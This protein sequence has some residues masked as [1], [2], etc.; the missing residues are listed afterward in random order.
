MQKKRENDPKKR[1]LGKCWIREGKEKK[2]VK[3]LS[4]ND[5]DI[6]GNDDPESWPLQTVTIRH[7]NGETVDQPIHRVICIGDN[8]PPSKK[9]KK[10]KNESQLQSQIQDN[11][12]VSDCSAYEKDTV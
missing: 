3:L 9:V 5:V 8:L 7:S 12:S 2:R 6:T 10:N 1:Y 4:F 11:M